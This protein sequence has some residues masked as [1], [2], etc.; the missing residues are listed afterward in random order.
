MNLIYEC[1]KLPP[2]EIT[3]A[4][5]RAICEAKLKFEGAMFLFRAYTY[6]Q[7]RASCS[8]NV[9]LCLLHRDGEER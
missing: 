1:N 3:P 8:E 2:M 6:G 7:G 4:A 5:A 9:G